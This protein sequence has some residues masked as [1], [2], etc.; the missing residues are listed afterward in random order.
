MKRKT[1]IRGEAGQSAPSMA[2]INAQVG[3]LLNAFE[4]FKHKNDE[5][6]ESRFSDVVRQEEL[7]RINTELTEVQ[8]WIDEASRLR[9]VGALEGGNALSAEA[10][11][12]AQEMMQFIRRGTPPQSAASVGSDPDGGYLVGEQIEA[13]ISRV[14]GTLSVLR[15]LA[16][17]RSMSAA[18]YKRVRSVGGAT[19]GWVGETEARTATTTPTLQVLE[20]PAHEQYA[21]PITTQTLL[22][23]GE[24]D[25]EAWLTDEA[26]IAF[27]DA[28]GLAFIQGNAGD[29]PR[30]FISGYTPVANASFDVANPRLGYVVTGVS[31][32][33]NTD[34]S[35][36]ASPGDAL[37]NTVHALKP[38]LRGGGRWLMNDTSLAVVRKLKDTDGRYYWEPSY[39]AGAPST[40][41]GYPVSTD[42]N[43]PDIAANAYAIAF[44][45]FARGYIILDRVGTRILRDPFTNKPYVQF[46]MTKRTGGGIQDFEAIKLLK[47]GTS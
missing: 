17:V 29:R 7:D 12:Q 9:D 28:E 41:F 39:Q 1:L 31:G 33:F 34:A 35:P 25:V 22:D 6:L 32:A 10:R 4:E 45:D 16:T 2:E 3:R 36:T 46:Y 30:G 19:Q 11:Q 43:M 38:Q 13:G 20:F 26:T 47:F 23:D 42:D 18:S 44:G 27:D 14:L 8:S 40:L 15:Q 5:D 21:M 24:F 37:I